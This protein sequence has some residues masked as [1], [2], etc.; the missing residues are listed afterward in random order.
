MLAATSEFRT[1]KAWKR[2][3]VNVI[4]S[5]RRNWIDC[6]APLESTTTPSSADREDDG[7]KLVINGVPQIQPSISYSATPNIIWPPDV[8]SVEVTVSGT[9]TPGTQAIP[10][11][12]ITYAVTDEYGLAQPR[13]SFTADV[14]GSYSFTAPLI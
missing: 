10:A 6:L 13:G 9:V 3:P 11:G 7:E 8:K 1:G 4:R 12:G 2:A 5:S 14:E